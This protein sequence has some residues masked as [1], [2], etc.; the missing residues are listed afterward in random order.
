MNREVISDVQGICLVILFIA[1]STLALPTASAAGSDLWLAILLAIVLAIPLYAAYSRLL[2]LYPGNDLFDIL[3]EIFGKIFGK[4]IGLIFVWFA[5]HLGV[6]VLREHGEYL[7]TLSLPET[8]IM[9]PTVILTLLCVFAVKAGIEALGR[10]AKLFVILN[11]PIPTITI[12]LLIPQMDFDNIQPI[13]FNGIKP[14]M[15]GTLQALIFPFGD[16]AV[17]LM[18]FF[19]LKTKKSSYNAFIKGLLFG[20][21]LIAGVS[22]AEILV[23]GEDLYAMTL[24]PNHNVAAKVSIGELLNRMEVISIIATLTSIFLKMSVCLLAACNGLAKILGFNDYRFIV[25]PIALLMANISYFV[26]ESMVDKY[27]WI[28]DVTVYYFFPFQIVLPILILIAAEIKTRR[29][30]QGK[31]KAG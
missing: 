9:V 20:G 26:Y 31:T 10:W 1:G 5:F 8:P 27:N 16:V 11:G 22:L 15:Q 28:A 12:L 30:R 21:I 17:F 18:V 14:L 4:L 25:V 19:A 23:L 2:S 6:L 29:N 24:Y 3:E 13:L 7:I